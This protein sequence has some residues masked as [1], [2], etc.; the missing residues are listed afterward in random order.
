MNTRNVLEDEITRI[1]E[2]L[3]DMEPGTEEYEKLSNLL[4]K[5]IDRR[6]ELEKADYEVDEKAQAR[7]DSNELKIQQLNEAKKDRIA[8]VAM[9]AVGGISGGVVSI[10]AALKAFKFDGDG[11]IFSSTFGRDSVK[12]LINLKK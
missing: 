2:K 1:S 10:W 12:K 3:G 11:R 6:T 4:H 7:E 5:Y 9:W 8:K